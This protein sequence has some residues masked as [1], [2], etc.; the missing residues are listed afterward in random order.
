[1]K[2]VWSRL[3]TQLGEWSENFEQDSNIVGMADF[4]LP[5]FKFSGNVE[6]WLLLLHGVLNII[7]PPPFSF[8]I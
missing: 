7:H 1:M 5:H 3:R 8:E 2:K 6:M 4:R